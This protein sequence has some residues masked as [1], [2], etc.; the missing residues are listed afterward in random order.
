M[1]DILLI[2]NYWHFEEEKSSSRYRFL[3]DLISRKGYSLEVVTSSFYHGSKKQRVNIDGCL[4]KLNYKVNL[5]NEPGY[6]KN[7]S[8]KRIYSHYKFAKNVEKFLKR[9]CA[10]DLIYCVVPSLDVADKVSKFAVKNKIPLIVDIQ[11]LWPEA[12]RMAIDIPIVNEILF[13]PME[14]KA[15]NIYKRADKIV[16]VSET[17]VERALKVNT[18]VQNGLSAYL[19]VDLNEFDKIYHEYDKV[20][21]PHGEKWITYIGTLG[22]S[23]NIPLVIDAMKILMNKGRKDIKFKVLG[24]GPL[25][26]RFEVYASNLS[27]NIDFIGRVDYKTVVNYLKKSDLAV[28]PIIDKSVASIINKV[29]D[30]AAAG[31][32]V[33]NTQKSYEYQRLLHEYKAGIS[34][35]NN[36]PGQFAIEILN[37][38]DNDVLIQSMSKNSRRLAEEKFN[39]WKSY[40]YIIDTID[41]LLGI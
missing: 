12:Y 6:K 35:G 11:D 27:M 16:A 34:C 22:H 33:I 31:L 37:I 4:E 2:T 26:E 29:G 28:N 19:G 18:K 36:D 38:I 1:K 40:N 8:I 21:K 41:S 32:P 13:K 25:K 14:V 10:P 9:R 5:V 24:D 15:N 3:A 39:R 20:E 30:Y 23:Y 17:Y 7:I